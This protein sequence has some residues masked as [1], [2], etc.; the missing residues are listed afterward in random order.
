[1]SYFNTMLPGGSDAT[2]RRKA[3]RAAGAGIVLTDLDTACTV[4][5][6][7]AKAARRAEVM[8]EVERDLAMRQAKRMLAA[9]AAKKDAV[10]R[11]AS[12]RATQRA[13]ERA[14]RK[15]LDRQRE[16]MRRANLDWFLDHA[17]R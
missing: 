8:K 16:R 2:S 3:R 15:D 12:H 7:A 4:T 13:I 17:T 9:H 11:A 6:E 10:A 14:E 1:M 5:D